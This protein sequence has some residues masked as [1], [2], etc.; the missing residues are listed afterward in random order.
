[1]TVILPLT[2]P[3]LF[4]QKLADL[5][6]LRPANLLA[7]NRCFSLMFVK[8]LMHPKGE[9][10]FDCEILLLVVVVTVS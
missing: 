1:M 9:I 3:S 6:G 8:T 5:A 4:L 10:F 7:L 2:V